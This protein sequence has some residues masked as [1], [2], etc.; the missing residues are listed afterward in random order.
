MHDMIRFTLAN[1][2][3]E[4]VRVNALAN[5]FLEQLGSAEE[6]VYVTNLAL[7]E[8]LSNVI[9]HGYEDSARHEIAV[10]L[11]AG[12]GGLD[13]QFVDDGREF[14]PTPVPAVDVHAPLEE[15]QVGGLGI[16][17]LRTMA[18]EIRYQRTGGKNHL[19]VSI[20]PAG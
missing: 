12:D 3:R 13:L 17:L 6:I 20:R 19:Q 1:D 10:C 16:H 4:L 7:E 2:L 11:R 14:D 9:R 5:A 15:R 18:R 8:V